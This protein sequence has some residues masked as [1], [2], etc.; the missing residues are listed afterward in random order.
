[1]VTLWDGLP[2]ADAAQTAARLIIGYG[3]RFSG[4]SE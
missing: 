3:R 2:W 4:I 1:M